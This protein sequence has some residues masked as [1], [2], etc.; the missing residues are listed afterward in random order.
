MKLSYPV[1]LLIAAAGVL[2]L[3]FVL[4]PDVPPEQIQ[5]QPDPTISQ[6]VVQQLQ[7]AVE[8]G[9]LRRFAGRFADT[10]QRV[11]RHVYRLP[12]FERSAVVIEAE[13]VVS[14]GRATRHGG[15]VQLAGDVKTSAL[16]L[17]WSPANGASPS[18]RRE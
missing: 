8:S 11:A 7:E 2:V 14:A 3:G 1:V 6:A 9:S 10:A 4:R 5:E 13:R 12:E 18:V 15:A 16:P 17:L